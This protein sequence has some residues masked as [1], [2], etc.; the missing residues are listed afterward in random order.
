MFV[1]TC[2]K[3]S[4][5]AIQALKNIVSQSLAESNIFNPVRH[6]VSY[7]TMTGSV[8]CFLHLLSG[9]PVVVPPLDNDGLLYSA[10]KGKPQ[11]I[12]DNCSLFVVHYS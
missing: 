11:V 3:S 1:L 12:D 10:M 6:I 5:N 4:I 8:E 9:K 7:L 2:Y